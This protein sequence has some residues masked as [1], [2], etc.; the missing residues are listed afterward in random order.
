MMSNEQQMMTNLIY[1]YFIPI[2]LA[3]IDSSRP[4]LKK[5]M[6][7]PRGLASTSVQEYQRADGSLQGCHD[8][9][10]VQTH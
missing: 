5:L 9:R 1:Q 3:K 2:G 8:G 7:N 6:M 10:R 4:R